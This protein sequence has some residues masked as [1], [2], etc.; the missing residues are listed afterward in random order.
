MVKAAKRVFVLFLAL[1]MA[2]SLA[3]CGR[4]PT[5]DPKQTFVQANAGRSNVSVLSGGGSQ[6]LLPAQS[7]QLLPGDGVD[8]DAT[9][10]ALLRFSDFLT[11]EVLRDGELVV[12]ELDL[13]DQS[14]L[15]VFGASGGALVN[16]MAPGSAE[17]KRR[18]TIETEFA[19]I[20]ATGTK[21]MVAKEANSPLEWIFGLDAG[22]DDLYI[23]S[24]SD[25]DPANRQPVESGVAR[26]VAPIGSPSPGIK[27]DV[28]NVAK[29]LAGV[30]AGSPVPEVG[31]VLWPQADLRMDTG[32][33]PMSALNG[34]AFSVEGVTISWQVT[35]DFGK[36]VYTRQDCNG[37][38]I[39]DVVVENGVMEMDFRAMLSRVSGLDVTLMALDGGARGTV[40]TFDPAKQEIARQS[41]DIP[42]GSGQIVSTRSDQP[43]HYARINLE[44]GCFLGIS[45]PPAPPMADGSG[46]TK[47]DP[48]PAVD[49]WPPGS[50]SPANTCEIVYQG[51]DGLNLR[52]GP[53]TVYDPPI[54]P[55][56]A[57]TLLEPFARSDDGRW[58]QVRVVDSEEMEGWVSGGQAYVRCELAIGDLPV[59]RI[60]ALPTPAPTPTPQAYVRIDQPGDNSTTTATGFLL[61][62]ES[63]FPIDG[64]LNILIESADG[65]PIQTDSVTVESRGGQ[66]Y[67]EDPAFFQKQI[68]VDTALPQPVRV[69]VQHLSA[70]DSSVVAEDSVLLRPLAADNLKTRRPSAN[71]LAEAWPVNSDGYSGFQVAMQIDGLPY[72]WQLLQSEFSVLPVELTAP[73]GGDDC[74]V[75]TP[76]LSASFTDL[77]AQAIFAYDNAG[78]YAAFFVQ[79]DTY[80][81]YSGADERFFLGDSPQIILDLDLG[82][83]LTTTTN[84]A[85]DVQ[86]DLHPGDFL[87]GAGENARAALWRLDTLTS[88]PLD[89]AVASSQAGF[90]YFVEAAIP[91]SSLG[92]SGPPPWGLGL[93]ASVSDNDTP[94]ANQQQCMI[95]MAPNRDFRNPTTW[96]TLDLVVFQ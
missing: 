89:A 54:T 55:L 33:M 4:E 45:L 24:K 52:T 3:G 46:P 96:G 35:T 34:D 39:D 62:G 79:D 50:A 92:L 74:G 91:W 85:D 93:A 20:T 87:E 15:A 65:Q 44:R 37:D 53:G 12:K 78:L 58:I 41:F 71:G 47:V 13:S 11:V 81:G 18:V 32:K 38:T 16:D 27:Y 60:P 1:L 49:V 5:P 77:A 72:E 86:I 10:Q 82:G 84:S 95:S 26:W 69:R 57:G 31:E 21:F 75:S 9:G 90:G 80:V 6:P 36:A 40:Q 30:E 56:Y 67:S 43:Y 19:L 64:T 42:A 25:R 59:G 29:W 8:V 2:L 51:A 63:S 48:V 73:V 76:G 14:A 88:Q 68:F 28:A 22:P 83:D 70:T 7:V 23:R 66:P 94:G 61:A 17:V